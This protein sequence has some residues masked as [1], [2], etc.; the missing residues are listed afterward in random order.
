MFLKKIFGVMGSPVP[1]FQNMW[2]L[3]HFLIFIYDCASFDHFQKLF[4]VIFWSF[5]CWPCYFYYINHCLEL[6]HE[7]AKLLKFDISLKSMEQWQYSV[8]FTF[9]NQVIIYFNDTMICNILPN[10][11][12][13]LLNLFLSILL[14]NLTIK[15]YWWNKCKCYSTG[16]FSHPFNS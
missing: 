8:F 3:D 6:F 5:F 10:M 12:L 9:F 16:K 15:F 7:N 1:L 11:C 4:C 2:K 14:F 13:I